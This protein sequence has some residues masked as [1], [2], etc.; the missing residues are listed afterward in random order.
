MFNDLVYENPSNYSDSK[1]GTEMLFICVIPRCQDTLLDTVI[2]QFA[3]TLLVFNNGLVTGLDRTSRY[4]IAAFFLALCMSIRLIPMLISTT[5]CCLY[6]HLACFISSVF[7]V[8]IQDASPWL[9]GGCLV[10][11]CS[12]TKFPRKDI[13][14]SLLSTRGNTQLFLSQ[15]RERTCDGQSQTS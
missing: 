2:F 8:C 1:W 14:Q 3:G 10:L 9:E 12:R 7:F 5:F 11:L 4:S 15:E 13:R 6:W